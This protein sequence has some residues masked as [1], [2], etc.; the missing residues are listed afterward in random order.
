[1]RSLL[2]AVILITLSVNIS[3][4]LKKTNP[5]KKYE[6]KIFTDIKFTELFCAP[7]LKR[8]ETE[9]SNELEIGCKDEQGKLQGI[10]IRLDSKRKKTKAQIYR[11][12]DLTHD[13]TV[14]WDENG[15]IN[16]TEE[17]DTS[18]FWYDFKKR[19]KRIETLIQGLIKRLVL[20]IQTI[21]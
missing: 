2:P 9:L 17:K 11:D 8:V 6:Q 10:A 12:G 15:K 16:Y 7:G 21:N 3:Y 5:P 13:H 1:M 19:K 4:G 14:T 18:I 20:G